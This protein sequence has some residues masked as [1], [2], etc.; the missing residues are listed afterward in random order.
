MASSLSR[1]P[2]IL[3]GSTA[4]TSASVFSPSAGRVAVKPCTSVLMASARSMTEPKRSD[5]A[6]R[7]AVVLLMS[8]SVVP[9]CAG[10][11]AAKRASVRCTMPCMR[12]DASAIPAAA[13]DAWSSSTATLSEFCAS[14]PVKLR[15][16]LIAWEMSSVFSDTTRSSDCNVSSVRDRMPRAPA[17]RSC[18]LER[19]ATI[20]GSGIV[21]QIDFAV[22]EPPAI[23]T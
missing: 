11:T 21:S 1:V 8:V 4:A 3:S 12:P 5:C 15:T 22:G 14:A 2:E 19:R 6:A 10:S 7:L 20:A 16:S 13:A 9:S 23:S 18:M 17:S